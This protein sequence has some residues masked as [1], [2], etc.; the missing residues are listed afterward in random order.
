[1]GRFK[2]SSA[3]DLA[4]QGDTASIESVKRVYEVAA[5]VPLD[6]GGYTVTLDGRAVRTPAKAALALPTLVL[7]EGVAA[8]WDAQGD[9]VVPDSMPLM[10]LAATAI[11]RVIPNHAAVAAEAAGYAGSDLLC[12][13][14]DTPVELAQRQADGWDPVLEWAQ[15]RYDVTFAVT[16]GLMPIDQPEETLARFQGVAVELEPF[17]LTAVHVLTTAFGS[18]LLALSVVEKAQ[19]VE[20]AFQLS[21]IDETYQEELWGS[22]EEAEKRRARLH[23]E[24]H[25]ADHYLSLL[26]SG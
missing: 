7:A 22:D 16:A 2:A 13:R 3:T 4:V 6:E 11:D 5:A 10:T 15:S 26:T 8:E 21:R 17:A 19:S 23:A 25:S 14:A 12:Y 20:E 1:M 24:V 9:K 18:F